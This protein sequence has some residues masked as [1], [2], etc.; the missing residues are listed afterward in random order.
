MRTQQHTKGP[1]QWHQEGQAI[2]I[3][4]HQGHGPQIP[5]QSKVCQEIQWIQ[6]LT[7]R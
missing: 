3:C 1:C 6:A 4:I 5:A 2:Q 7:R